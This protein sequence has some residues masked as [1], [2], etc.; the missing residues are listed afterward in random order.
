MPPAFP[1]G[2]TRRHRPDATAGRG[3]LRL[4]ITWPRV[5]P[6]GDG[7]VIAKDHA[8]YDELIDALREAGIIPSVT[9]YH[10]DLPQPPQDCG[11]WPERDTAHA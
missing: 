4:S 1:E 9:L 10:W 11:G 5:F 6:D 8:C 2:L 7:P 3:R